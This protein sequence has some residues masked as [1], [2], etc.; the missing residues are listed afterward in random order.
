M[1]AKE[2]ALTGRDVRLLRDSQVRDGVGSFARPLIEQTC[3]R[4]EAGDLRFVPEDQEG[5]GAEREPGRRPERQSRRSR[6]HHGFTEISD[7]H[8][9]TV[10]SDERQ[11]EF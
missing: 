2:P 3:G 5:G 11:S 8:F 4:A 10:I 7:R 6:L 9:Q 1:P